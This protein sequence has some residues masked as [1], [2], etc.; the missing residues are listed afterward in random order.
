MFSVYSQTLQSKLMYIC[1]KTMK[2]DTPKLWILC[3]TSI[4]HYDSSDRDDDT[5]VI[6][7]SAKWLPLIEFQS[8]V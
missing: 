2:Q 6:G 1:V 5:P 3:D 8:P 4:T 7:Y